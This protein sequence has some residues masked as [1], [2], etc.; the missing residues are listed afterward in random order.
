MSAELTIS[1]AAFSIEML[2]T[3][4]IVGFLPHLVVQAPNLGPR[5]L[6]TAAD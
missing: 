4:N 5:V 6:R 3:F 1:A 2:F